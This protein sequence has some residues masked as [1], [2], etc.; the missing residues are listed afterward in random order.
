MYVGGWGVDA[1]VY[2]VLFLTLTGLD[3]SQAFVALHLVSTFALG[4]QCLAIQ[5]SKRYAALSL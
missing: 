5:Y 4:I 1:S 2:L 3:C